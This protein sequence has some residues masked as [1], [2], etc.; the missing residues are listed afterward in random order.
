MARFFSRFYLGLIFFFLFSPLVV[1]ILF[2]FHK[3]SDPTRW[4]PNLFTLHWFIVMF[5]DKDIMA[6]IQNSLIVG[7]VAVSIAAVF[8]TM[9]ALAIF[10]YRFKFATIF[11]ALTMLPS[12]VPG[13]VLGVSLLLLFST[14]KIELSLFTIVIGHVT[15]LTPVIMTS[16]LSRL[17]RL[18][19][20]LEHASRDL[21]A[22]QFQSFFL[23]ILPNI[24]TTLISSLLYAFMLSFDNI[25]LTFFLTGFQ[26][27]LPLEFWGR[28][29]FG[30]NPA[31]NAVATLLLCF[32]A[33][34]LLGSN[35]IMREEKS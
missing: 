8:G 3:G 22:S 6:A 35:W 7:I 1:I 18:P 23:V 29:R 4:P 17:E 14:F 31:T 12:F 30:L 11:Y 25:V 10:H 19:S 24:R 5:E 27:T 16:I 32:S 2:A 26:K 9:V 21:G 20:N 33:I 15:F 34:L 28:I 13:L